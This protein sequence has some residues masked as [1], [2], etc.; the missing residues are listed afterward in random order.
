MEK[1]YMNNDN[2]KKKQSVVSQVLKAPLSKKLSVS[3][4]LVAFFSFL[5][6]GVSNVSFAAPA[7]ITQDLGDS[8]T[9]AAVTNSVIGEGGAQAAP[10]QVFY[11][12]TKG[13]PIFCLERNIDYE[14]NTTLQKTE[15][16]SDQGLLYVMANTYPHVV[17]KDANGVEFPKEVQTWIT[18]V[19]IWDYLFQT[20]D[21]ADG[22]V[23]E[24]QLRAKNVLEPEK[25]DNM[26]KSFKIYWQ[27]DAAS[28]TY[29]CDINGCSESEANIT[30][31][32]P[33]YTQYIQP[34]V[35]NALSA[36]GITAKFNIT[37]ANED[38]SVTDDNNYYQSSLI[39][40]TNS[41]AAN[42]V[43]YSVT[44]NGPDGTILVDENGKEIKNLDTMSVDKFYVRVPVN[45][46]TEDKK[47]V[48]ISA[49]GKFRGYDGYYYT[50]TLANGKP[51]Q[52]VSSVFTADVPVNKGVDIALN[53]TPEVPDTSMTVAQSVYFIGLIVLLCGVGI[54]YANAKPKQQQ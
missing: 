5:L 34:L 46:V 21:R 31:A 4:T 38:I 36:T 40:V 32:T 43:G 44:V 50:G 11:S 6:I 39:T 29:Y 24:Q 48:S 23:F 12:T 15:Q 52:T 54:I 19:A 41:D 26:R 17:F 18:Q 8:F 20:K 37:K 47:T 10:V 9:T 33:F 27:D 7:P 28:K 42:F 2:N 1:I 14:A 35:T 49:F 25:L 13:I 30:S 16:I 22:T 3:M 53:Y 45:K 51:A